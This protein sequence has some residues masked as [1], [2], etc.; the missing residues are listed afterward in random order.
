[1]VLFFKSN[2]FIA[3]HQYAQIVTFTTKPT[4]NA[5]NRERM[6]I[7]FSQSKSPRTV[8]SS[9]DNSHDSSVALTLVQVLPLPAEL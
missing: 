5:A 3:L 1:M 8:N 4:K 6:Y 7:H 2:G 9:R